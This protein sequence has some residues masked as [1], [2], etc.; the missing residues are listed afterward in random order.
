M[1]KTTRIFFAADLH[2]SAVCFRKFVNAAKVYR[3]NVLLIGGDVA[4]KTMTPIFAASGGWT[5]D[6]DGEKRTARSSEELERLEGWIRDSA[7]VPFRTTPEEWR[8]LIQDRPRADAKFQE[9]ELDELRRWLDW[10]KVRLA[11]S[12]ARLLLGLGNDDFTPMERVIAADGFAELTDDRILR[13]D[14]RH[15]LL[16]L[17]YSNPTPWHPNRELPEEEIARRQMRGRGGVVSVS[18]RGGAS[19]LDRFLRHLRLVHVASSLGSVES[20]AS[21]PGETSHR[22]LSDAER[23]ERGIDAGLVRLSLGVEDPDDLV[24]D[25]REALDT[26][27]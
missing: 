3:A 16:T 7:T 6:V 24:R 26:V 14:D 25:L 9:L 27:D 23:A 1:A 11:G 21:V 15:E 4:A 22:H 19:A 2:G 20:L 8:D 10:A 17:P 12:G 18:L 13:V 5:V